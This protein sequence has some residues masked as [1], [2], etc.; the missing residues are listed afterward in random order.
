MVGFW[1][2]SKVFTLGLLGFCWA[3]N[4]WIIGKGVWVVFWVLYPEVKLGV[5]RGFQWFASI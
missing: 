1:G 2:V 4:C 5:F 3:V